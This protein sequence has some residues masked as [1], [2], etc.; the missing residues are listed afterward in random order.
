MST[1]FDLGHNPVL[2]SLRRNGQAAGDSENVRFGGQSLVEFLVFPER[3]FELR[4]LTVE[5]FALRF[6]VSPQD[7]VRA[8]SREKL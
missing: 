1:R 3:R 6:L 8:P 7:A 5:Q 2:E 4:Q